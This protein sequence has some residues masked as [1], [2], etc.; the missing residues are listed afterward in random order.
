MRIPNRLLPA[1]KREPEEPKVVH[2]PVKS[3]DSGV[4]IKVS[5]ELQRIKGQLSKRRA[6]KYVFSMIRDSDGLLTEVVASPVEHDT[7]V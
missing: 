4:L 2:V 1:V 3:D 6:P 7:I 5:E